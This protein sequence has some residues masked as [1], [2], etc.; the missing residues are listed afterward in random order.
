MPASHAAGKTSRAAVFSQANAAGDAALPAVELEVAAINAAF[1]SGK[2][3]SVRGPALNRSAFKQLAFTGFD[4]VHIASHAENDPGDASLSRLLIG[5]SADEVL[6]ASDINLLRIPV[7]LV[8]LSGCE[9]A[10]GTDL[11]GNGVGGFAQAFMVAGAETVIASLWKIPDAAAAE[12]MKHFYTA[13]SA[14]PTSPQRALALAQDA[15]RHDARW[16][17][18]FYWSGFV[19]I[20]RAPA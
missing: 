7:P 15:L 14:A 17:H 8:V 1:G 16:A 13:L 9:T 5:E 12:L 6:L 10:L 18:P 19:T 4:V 3:A 20:T 2:V 11:P